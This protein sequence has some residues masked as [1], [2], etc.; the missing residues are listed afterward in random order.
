MNRASTRQRAAR[1]RLIRRFR[2]AASTRNALRYNRIMSTSASYR[3]R[4]ELKLVDGVTTSAS[5]N[6]VALN[7]STNHTLMNGIAVGANYFNRV[8][9]RIEMQS[10]HLKGIIDFT[11]H[12]T[13]LIDQAR[14]VVVY[15]RQPNGA[16]PTTATVLAD[17]DSSGAGNSTS[18][19]S[20]VNPDERERFLILADIRLTLP[21]TTAGQYSA[22]DPMQNAFQINRYI[23]LRGLKTH[24]LG[25]TDVIGSISTGSLFILGMGQLA[26]GSEGYQFTGTWRLRYA[27]T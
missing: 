20:G 13:T 23:P 11:G 12:N 2:G 3:G 26:A 22:V 15:D 17:M 18:V 8:G 27:D 1:K 24:Y 4:G 9:R 6:A 16:L 19:F 7:T 10:L 21:P 14:L 5:N 25:D